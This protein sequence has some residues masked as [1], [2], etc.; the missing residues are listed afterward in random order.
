MENNIAVL[1]DFENL[2]AGVEKE[3]LG[4]LEIGLIMNRLRERG[5]VLVARSYADWGRFAR[6]KK[7]LLFE[8]ISLFE[9]SAH[10]MQDKNRADVALVVDCMELAFT[11]S[12]VD[13]YCIVSGD[14]DFT[15]LITK[16]REL[17]K[18]VLGCGTRRSTSRLIIE[19]CDEF[20]F[21]DTLR[22][23]RTQRSRRKGKSEEV[24]E[25]TREEA[26]ELVTEALESLQRDDP[27][28]VQAS[29]IKEAI[30][31]KESSFSEAD[32]GF[33]TMT[34]FMEFCARN[35]VVRLER[36]ERG[37][38]YLVG[39]PDLEPVEH[40]RPPPA[41]IPVDSDPTRK[42]YEQ[43]TAEELEPLT[44]SDRAELCRA[45]HEAVRQR[46]ERKRRVNLQWMIQDLTNRAH[47]RGDPL[48]QRQ[49]ESVINALHRGGAFLH[50]DGEAVRSFFAP[51]VL[52]RSPEDLVKLLDQVYVSRLKEL[53]VE[54]KS[55]VP[56]LSELLFGDRRHTREVEEL[57]AWSARPAPPPRAPRPM[58]VE[59]TDED[60][61][62]ELAAPPPRRDRRDT[63]PLADLDDD[64]A[65]GGK[66][67]RR[68]RR[69]GDRGD[70]RGDGERADEPR[71][72]Q[73][74]EERQAPAPIA[75]A[76]VEVE[77]EPLPPSVE[78][79][80]LTPVVEEAPAPAPRKGRERTRT[81]RSEAPKE[82]AAVAVVEPVAAPVAEPVAAEEAEPA[83]DGA[84]KRRRRP[85]KG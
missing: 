73:E 34:R 20:F 4:K 44:R 3:G 8:G 17:D 36:D 10:G 13:T 54:L 1:I 28:P 14:S 64:S 72:E 80:E 56:E 37:G 27:A 66:R 75:A 38:G 79:V 2:A 78:D 18:R 9:L 16:L 12:Y 65:T 24:T 61:D 33:S 39:A 45:L 29:K 46:N 51:F 81:R 50:P 59:P 11:K 26:M 68:R 43:L 42:L 84:P 41:P 15:P 57:L 69:R 76:P 52:D 55:S 5:R 58:S 49:V 25:F 71:A 32:L 7:E 63:P 85:R 62:A 6:H 74:V 60:G 31:R 83:G 40:Q 67:R 30:L 22:S 47:E 48:T 23:E 35:G 82:A 70:E 53:G 19:A 21:Y 77:E